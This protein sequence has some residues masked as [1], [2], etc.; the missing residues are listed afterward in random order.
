MINH[1]LKNIS[2]ITL[3][4]NLME[5]VSSGLLDTK[6]EEDLQLFDYSRETTFTKSWDLYTLSCRGLVLDLKEKKIKGYCLPKFFNLGEFGFNIEELPKEPYEVFEKCDGSLG[7]AYIYDGRWKVNTRGSFS[8]DQAIWATNWLNDNKVPIQIGQNRTLIFE[9][10]YPENRIV[11]DYRG[12]SG[13]VL[14][15]WY[16]DGEERPLEAIVDELAGTPIR[17]V[18]SRPFDSIEDIIKVCEDLDHNAEGFV[19]RFASGTRIKIKGSKYCEVHKLM[20]K[21]TPLGV[22]EIM[23]SGSDINES[24]KNLPE[25]FQ[26]E[27]HD[28]KNAILDKQLSII[29]TLME[30]SLEMDAEDFYSRKEVAIWI[31]KNVNP[32]YRGYMFMILDA[33]NKNWEYIARINDKILKDL[34][35]NGN[36]LEGYVPRGVA[37]RFAEQN[38]G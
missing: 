22:W 6:I 15:A 19:V 17:V 38:D 11:V 30:Y 32:I 28:I 12:W 37:N 13:L 2:F 20:S 24:I 26:A 3:Y 23:V 8:S 10:I 29:N 31:M 36:V 4:S 14:L 5:R 18:A 35:P 7:I 1:P 27:F 33:H 34:R 25:E 21:V 16:Q 9:I